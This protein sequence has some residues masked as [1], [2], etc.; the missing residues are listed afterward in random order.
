VVCAMPSGFFVVLYIYFI[1]CFFFFQAEDG[2][3]DRNVNGV[4][5]CALPISINC[6]K[7]KPTKLNN[8]VIA[9]IREM[10]A[11]SIIATLTAILKPSVAL[12]PIIWKKGIFLGFAL[13][14]L[15][16]FSSAVKLEISTSLSSDL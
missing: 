2:I 13:A 8:T 14:L 16:I 7:S 15:E 1:L 3:R 5:T 11:S 4:Q 12:S 9:S 10:N 6:L